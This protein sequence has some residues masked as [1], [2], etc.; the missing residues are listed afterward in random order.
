M[1]DAMREAITQAEAGA[2]V[3]VRSGRIDGP[4]RINKPLTLVGATHKNP[5]NKL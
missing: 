4:L 3:V 1:K 5:V 2:T